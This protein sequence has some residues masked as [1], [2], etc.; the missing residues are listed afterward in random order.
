MVTQ[1]SPE[2]ALTPRWYS[3][4]LIQWALIVLAIGLL[5]F[6]YHYL[7]YLAEGHRKH[8][9]EPLINELTGA[10]TAGLLFFPILRLVRRYPLH[11]SDWWRVV[12]VYLA[13][14][15]AFGIAATSLMWLLREI[16]YPLLGRGDFDYG[17]MPLR[18]LMEFPLQVIIFSIMVGAIHGADAFR[19]ARERQI[20]AAQLEA[21][22]ARAELRSLRFQL[23]P[24]FLFNALNTVSSTMYRDP[25]AADEIL[26]RLAELLRASLNTA[27]TDEVPLA[28]EL[29]ILD[30][31][32]AV[33]D[34]RFGDRLTVE[35]DIAADAQRALVP[36]MLLQPLVENAI[37]H[38]SLE[39]S[40]RGRVW[41]R[42]SID[43]EE[44]SLL[45]EDD[46]P[47]SAV[48]N[49]MTT[50]GLGLSATADRLRLLHGDACRFETENLPRGGFRVA[51]TLPF[52]VEGEQSS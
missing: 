32:L 30:N 33:L 16:L 36:S 38:G 17:I 18:Y 23:Q 49:P 1:I 24:H 34:A 43:G 14:L 25:N 7:A 45:V 8:V 47:G 21:S 12:P 29:E 26:D 51:I 37:R 6:A 48:D 42:S 22:L 11:R 35:I 13:G 3:R 2:G 20:H 19:A 9:A 27:R 31:Y 41:I 4:P 52:R 5:M 15:V 10:F 50:N 28:D 46:G 40:G 44:L 39:Q